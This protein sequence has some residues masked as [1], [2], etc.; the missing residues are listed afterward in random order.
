MTAIKAQIGESKGFCRVFL[1][2][3]LNPIL[4]GVFDLFF[5]CRT[6]FGPS[7]LVSRP[8]KL[9]SI[10]TEHR[11]HQFESLMGIVK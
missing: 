4:S 7:Q 2:I 11:G 6:S 10:A 5:M 3:L 8:V 9:A 1:I